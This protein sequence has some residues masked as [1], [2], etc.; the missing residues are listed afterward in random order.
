MDYSDTVQKV[1]EN[2]KLTYYPAEFPGFTRESR[3]KHDLA[4]EVI[5]QLE[6]IL[7]LDHPKEIKFS[8]SRHHTFIGYDALTQLY[9]FSVAAICN[10]IYGREPLAYQFPKIKGEILKAILPDNRTNFDYFHNPILEKIEK[11]VSE[12][13]TKYFDEWIDVREFRDE[14][15][16]FKDEYQHKTDTELENHKKRLIAEITKTER[17]LDGNFSDLVGHFDTFKIKSVPDE[18]PQVM[19]LDVYW[20]EFNTIDKYRSWF[21]GLV[22]F[23]ESQK[24]KI[25]FRKPFEDEPQHLKD[26]LTWGMKCEPNTNSSMRESIFSVLDDT[27]QYGKTIRLLRAKIKAIDEILLNEKPV[28]DKSKTIEY[29]AEIASENLDNTFYAKKFMISY[30]TK[31]SENPECNFLSKLGYPNKHA[32]LKADVKKEMPDLDVSEPTL[33]NWVKKYLEW[34]SRF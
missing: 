19:C 18:K 34:E 21:N 13:T 4:M 27:Y 7:Q 30:F 10:V 24:Q 9:M 16:P 33:N 8:F 2:L 32:K 20:N 23:A 6:F 31:R 5:E 29:I 1:K 14:L 22:E 28:Q 11:K 15:A 17:L 12:I 25:K 3:E 26:L